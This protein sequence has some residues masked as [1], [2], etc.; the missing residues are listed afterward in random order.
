MES[1]KKI[2][3]EIQEI[4]AKGVSQG[5]EQQKTLELFDKKE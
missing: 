2:Q 1:L 4:K 3:D 5:N